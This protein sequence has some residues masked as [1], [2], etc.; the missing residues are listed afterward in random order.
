MPPY[1][2][3]GGHTLHQWFHDRSTVKETAYWKL[4]GRVYLGY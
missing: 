1:S 3:N 4:L 2:I